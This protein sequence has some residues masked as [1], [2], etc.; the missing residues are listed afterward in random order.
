MRCSQASG[1]M[2]CESSVAARS[3]RK[4]QL[5]WLYLTSG[6]SEK[7]GWME[8]FSLGT[9]VFVR[10]SA[11]PPQFHLTPSSPG[12]DPNARA[13]V[14]SLS[15]FLCQCDQRMAQQVNEQPGP[16][17]G[18]E[19]PETGRGWGGGCSP[20]WPRGKGRDRQILT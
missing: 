14:K 6:T 12:L 9:E 16:R 3:A 18:T 15:L 7:L 19:T 4:D 8:P 1:P 2:C 5:C 11:P 20:H 17:E 13:G 10:S